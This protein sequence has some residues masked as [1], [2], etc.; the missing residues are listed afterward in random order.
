MLKTI[1]ITFYII[2]SFFLLDI[3]DIFQTK[4]GFLKAILH[5]GVMLLPL[6]LLFLEIRA[7]RSLIK[8]VFRKI[9]PI[10]VIIGIVYINPLALLFSIR[11]WKTQTVERLINENKNHKIETQIKDVGAFG[12]AK[13]KV[14]VYDITPYFYI[15]LSKPGIK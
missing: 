5:F 14:E 1:R 10:L 12:H 2:L 9:I 11:P 4:I 3:F 8:A 7:N 13:R 15:I 6:L